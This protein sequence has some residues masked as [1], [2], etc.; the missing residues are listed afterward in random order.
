VASTHH[1]IEI[2]NESGLALNSNDFYFRING[3]LMVD[4]STWQ[5]AAFSGAVD[6]NG[7]GSEVR[8]SR[9]YLKG[10][11]RDW[12]Y[13]FQT[14]IDENGATNS[15][16]YIK[17]SGFDHINV[18]VGKHAEPFSLEG[19]NSSKYISAI[20]RTV[21]GNSHFA[22]DRELGISIAGNQTNYTYQIGVF[23]IASTAIDA[24]YAVTG[25][26]TYLPFNVGKQLLHLGLSVSSRQLDEK[27]PFEALDRA[28]VHSTDVKSITTDMFY[29]DS[30][31]VY[32]LEFS[33]R[34]SNWSLT[35]EY[36]LSEFSEINSLSTREF[37]SYYFQ[38]SYF[39]TDDR[40][41]YDAESGTFLG[42][43]PNGL[44]G[45]WE[46]FARLEKVDFLDKD[47]GSKAQ[48]FTTGINY[49]ATKHTRLSLDYIHS[50]IDYGL[51][52]Q[53]GE[54]IDGSAITFRAQFYW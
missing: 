10:M 40:R 53:N 46:V 36:L 54:S 5:G 48:I 19:S 30:S 24:N 2:S 4:F 8:R 6:K 52:T 22:G 29:A 51:L 37:S 17:Y 31:S 23:D 26:F 11:Y 33:Y 44:N 21:T 39:L 9:I 50:D 43:I 12:Q 49:F 18:F 25:R 38:S 42:I 3:R 14:N 7:A 13:R 32:N 45:A 47:Y 34:Y 27:T 16:T 41:P 28:G 1:D 20:E 15:N 35:G